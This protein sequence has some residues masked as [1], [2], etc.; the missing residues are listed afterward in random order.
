MNVQKSYLSAKPILYLVPTPI[1]NLLDMT[2]RAVETLKGVDYIFA[3]DTRVTKVLLS[4]FHITAPLLSY[5]IFNEEERANEILE[6]LKKKHH[7]ALVSDAGTPGICDPGYL[8]ASKAIDAG[9]HVV[10]LPGAAAFVMALVA[11]GLPSDRFTF[12]GFTNSRKAARIKELQ[13]FVNHQ[14]T[15]IFYESPHRIKDFLN[16][17]LGVFGNRDVVVARELTKKFEEYQRGK[18]EDIIANNETFKGELVVLVKGQSKDERNQKLNILSVKEHYQFYL[19]QNID[20]KEAM[21]KVA[22]DRG[23][24]KSDI[25]RQLQ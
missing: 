4:H 10:S 23:V 7:V 5:H 22:K 18:L 8:I 2:F 9:Y 11:S 6:L 16:D 17:L 24:A 12:I 1:G 14:E 19:K 25:Y 13:T 3:E 20:A 21:K 15:L